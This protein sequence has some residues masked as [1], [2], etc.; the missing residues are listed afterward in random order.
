[1]NVARY[2]VQ[3]VDVW[4]YPAGADT[5]QVIE[6]AIIKRLQSMCESAKLLGKSDQRNVILESKRDRLIASAREL[7]RT[8][9]T[10]DEKYKIGKELL[11][12]FYTD[13]NNL[14]GDSYKGDLKKLMELGEYLSTPSFAERD[15]I[16]FNEMNGD[17]EYYQRG[18]YLTGKQQT[19]IGDEGNLSLNAHKSLYINN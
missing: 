11:A 19:H 14:V 2:L 18:H 12:T 7:Y 10:F 16:V 13:I 9:M 3:G 5:T 1:M 15:L 17:A 6:E 4:L 8:H